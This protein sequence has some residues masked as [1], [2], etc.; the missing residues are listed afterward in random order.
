VQSRSF[1]KQAIEHI[2]E[3]IVSLY[4]QKLTYGEFARKR[5]EIGHEAMADELAFRQATLEQNQQRQSE[6]Q[7]PNNVDGTYAK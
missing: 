2:G 5:Y 6:A 4:Q 7:Q 3:L 1:Y